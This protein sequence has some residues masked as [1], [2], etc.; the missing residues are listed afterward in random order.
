MELPDHTCGSSVGPH[1]HGHTCADMQAHRCVYTDTHM[2]TG[3]H[4]HKWMAMKTGRT[5]AP[6]PRQLLG[7]ELNDSEPLHQA[8][9]LCQAS[10]HR[11]PRHAPRGRT[12]KPAR[13]GGAAGP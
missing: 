6:G 11:D 1:T 4:A 9:A 13:C 2:H 8:P 10:Q 5:M 12:V 3:T 7:A